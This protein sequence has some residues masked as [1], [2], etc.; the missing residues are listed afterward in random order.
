MQCSRKAKEGGASWKKQTRRSQPNSLRP[1]WVSGSA[2]A[3]YSTRLR[4]LIL[5]KSEKRPLNH[6]PARKS[7]QLLRKKSTGDSGSRSQFIFQSGKP[8][9]L[10]A[11]MQKRRIIFV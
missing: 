11:R 3:F 1:V 9:G 10:P 7:S 6:S 2:A 5:Q 4:P 8:E